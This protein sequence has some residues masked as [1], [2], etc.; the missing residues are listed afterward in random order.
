MRVAG[1]V[2]V[3]A[4]YGGL[5]PPQLADLAALMGD[6]ADNIP[7]VRGVGLKGAVALLQVRVALPLCA[8]R[9]CRACLMAAVCRLVCVRDTCVTAAGR[10][11][12]DV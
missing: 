11:H 6:A 3:R 7:G 12:V 10:Q 8:Q 5:R 4:R 9:A 2:E 1:E